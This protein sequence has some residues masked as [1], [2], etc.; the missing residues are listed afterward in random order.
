MNNAKF[1]KRIYGW[2]LDE[3][4]CLP[5]GVFCFWLI[6]YF[7]ASFPLF[8]LVVISILFDYFFYVLINSISMYAFKG[9][10]LGMTIEGIKTVDMEGNRPS[11]RC[12]FLKCFLNGVIAIDLVN[13]AFMLLIHTERSLFDRL[14]QTMA[15]NCR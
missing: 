14:S 12:C 5:F 13:A 3:A 11:Y 2:L 8:F 7:D 9:K 10:T 1:Y 15:V 6:Y 4:L